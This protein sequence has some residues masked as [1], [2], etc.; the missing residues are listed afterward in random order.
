MPKLITGLS[1]F[2]ITPQDA[3]GQVDTVALRALLSRLVEARVPSIGLLGSTGSYAYLTRSE[4]RRAVD[5]AVETVARRTLLLVGIGALRTEDVIL[6]AQD[7]KDAGADAGLLAPVSYTPLTEDEVYTHFE[8]V[9]RAVDLPLIIYNN[10][11]TTHFTFSTSLITRLSQLP[12]VIG[13]KNPGPPPAE[14]ASK[15][16][17]LLAAVPRGAGPTA[18]FS[19]GYSGDAVI[20]ESLLAGGDAWFSVVGGLFPAPCMEMVAAVQRG[21]AAEARRLHARLQPLW[22]LF[23]E[24][25]SF[26]VC[27]AAVNILGLCQAAAPLPILPLS[28]EATARVAVVLRELELA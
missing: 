11:G 26:R 5:A 9:T 3:H 18:D 16:S 21:D 23:K 20:A 14:A 15:H 25:T 1:A 22:E 6:L 2:P 24:L 13:V 10:P 4:R 8:A 17:A 7:A 27:Y 12:G 19:L 28:A